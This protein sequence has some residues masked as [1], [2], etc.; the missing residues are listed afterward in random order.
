MSPREIIAEAWLMTTRESKIFRW[1]LI[2]SVLETLFDLKIVT[3][4]LY[5]LYSYMQGDPIGFFKIEELLYEFLPFPVFLMVI[6][7]IIVLF[8]VEILATKLCMGAIIGLA[9]KSHKKEELKG[10]LVL[11]IYN[12]FPIFALQ[13]LFVLGKIGIAITICS[14]I[15]RYVGGG[16]AVPMIIITMT[17]W[18]VSLILRFFASFAEEASVIHKKGVFP[19]IRKS[20][21]L[22]ISHIG[23]VFF[24]LVLLVMISIRILINALVLFV[25]P[26][27]II[28]LALFL[29]LFLSHAVTIVITAIAG[30]ILVGF[31]SYFFAYL[32]VFQQTV[33]TITY[34]ELSKLKELDIIE[35]EPSG[36]SSPPEE[37][38][39]EV[40]EDGAQA[41]ASQPPKQQSA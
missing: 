18:L 15:L 5:F 41:E 14:L 32:H 3:Y 22:I 28:G 8:V 13:E 35:E 16:L 38:P 17:A 12:F 40:T 1:G 29:T 9:A 11:A 30:V 4:Q 34:M 2:S 27:I 23:H 7:S 25:I 24:L 21:K 37:E 26:A 39:E 33:W 31:A 19:A 20:I 6:I 10:G 36:P